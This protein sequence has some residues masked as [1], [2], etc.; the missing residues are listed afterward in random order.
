MNKK[1]EKEIRIYLT[2]NNFNILASVL[3]DFI[4]IS[5]NAKVDYMHVVSHFALSRLNGCIQYGKQAV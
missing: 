1:E 4:L 5:L 2:F 3:I